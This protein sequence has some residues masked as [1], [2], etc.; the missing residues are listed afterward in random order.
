MKNSI[1]ALVA[2]AREEEKTQRNG[3]EGD[4]VRGQSARTNRTAKES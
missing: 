2:I 4:E 1:K 3:N